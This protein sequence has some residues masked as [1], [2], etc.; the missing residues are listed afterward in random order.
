MRFVE[1]GC[2]RFDEGKQ[3]RRQP[4]RSSVQVDDLIARHGANAPLGAKNYYSHSLLQNLS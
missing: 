3:P 1:C 4:R 2:S